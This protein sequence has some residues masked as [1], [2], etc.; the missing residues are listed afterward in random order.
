MADIKLEDLV[1]D[2][3]IEIQGAPS[4]TIIH[5]L[6]RAATELCERTLI[7]E[8]WEEV[9]DAVSGEIEQDLPI[10]RNA[11]LVQLISIS[12]KGAELIPVPVRKIY[13]MQGDPL[14]EQRWAAHS[15]YSTDGILT[16]RMSPIPKVDEE[17][18]C[19]MALKPK[20][21]ATTI[22]YELGVRWRSAIQTGAKHFLCMMANTEWYDPNRAVYYRQ[23]FDRELGRAKVAQ[24]QGYDSTNLR[25]KSVRFGA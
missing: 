21:T 23:L 9:L 3:V 5:S 1:S 12:R 10:P 14:D 25:V 11:E 15:H 17:L 8:Q 16:T 4:F 6:R 2:V 22:P 24:I 7:W 18:E 13:Q 20:Q 19:R